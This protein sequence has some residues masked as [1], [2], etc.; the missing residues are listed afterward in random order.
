MRLNKE[1]QN[2]I[3][4]KKKVSAR[5]KTEEHRFEGLL[6]KKIRWRLR[7]WRGIVR[8]AKVMKESRGAEGLKVDNKA[9]MVSFTSNKYEIKTLRRQ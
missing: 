1:M 7:G 2:V 5:Y 8:K 9:G 6:G 3:K 4:A